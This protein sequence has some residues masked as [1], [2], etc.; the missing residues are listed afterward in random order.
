MKHIFL[1]ILL[2]LLGCGD[3]EFTGYSSGSSSNSYVLNMDVQIKSNTNFAISS[4]LVKLEWVLGYDSSIPDSAYTDSNGN[5][6]IQSQIDDIY[7][8]QSQIP[9]IYFYISSSGFLN[10]TTIIDGS[11]FNETMLDTTTSRYIQSINHT[12]Y[13][14]PE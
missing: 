3:I 7:Y 11:V 8:Y 1:I 12:I 4:A 10:D 2:F 5:V 13:L 6:N 9:Q 14:V